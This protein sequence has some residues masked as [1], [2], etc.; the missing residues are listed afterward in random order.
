LKEKRINRNLHYLGIDPDRSKLL[1]IGL[2][3]SIITLT[4]VVVALFSAPTRVVAN[5]E[6][7][8][9]SNE[10]T[11]SIDSSVLPTPT[12]TPTPPI[13]SNLQDFEFD[14]NGKLTANYL[15]YPQDEDEECEAHSLTIGTYESF[16]E[17][18]ALDSDG[19]ALKVV[20]PNYQHGDCVAAW[21]DVG[22]DRSVVGHTMPHLHYDDS[23]DSVGD[24]DIDLEEEAVPQT[25]R[26][27]LHDDV[28]R[29]EVCF[30]NYYSRQNPV[31]VYWYQDG[32]DE[33]QLT[34]ELAYG[35]KNT[36]CFYSYLGH[37]F[38]TY[39]IKDHAGE[40][41]EYEI[42]DELVIQYIL[43][44]AFGE[45]PPYQNF[46]K[47]TDDFERSIEQTL[48][49]EW[50]RHTIP[51]RT[52][53]PLGFAKGRLPGDVFASMGSFYYNNRMNK[54]REEWDGKGYFVNWWET[55]VY[56]VQV[57]WNLKEKIQIRLRD[58]VSEWAGTNVEQ[59]VM[60]GLRQYESGARLLTHVDRLRTHVVSLIVNIAQGNLTEDWPV[61]VYDHDGRLHEVTM[62]PGD[63][64]FY[65][66]AKNLH[67]RN[68]AL[69]GANGYYVNLFT[70]YRPTEEGDT[71]YE[72]ESQH[73]PL[74]DV[75]G[76]CHS[77]DDKGYGKVKCDDPRLGKFV[78]PTLFRAESG[79][80]LIKWWRYTTPGGYVEK[81]KEPSDAEDE[82][83]DYQTHIDDDFPPDL[84]EDDDD[85]YADDGDFAEEGH[86]D[87][88]YNEK[89]EEVK[90]EL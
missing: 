58:L 47:K 64:V 69:S 30:L 28:F 2:M 17:L 63:I 80:D 48:R 77:D 56:F 71:W 14:I 4:T 10:A 32:K 55:D 7:I 18:V 24:I 8:T 12:P 50:T 49:S 81:N 75:E 51:K 5:D 83:R 54:I 45:T 31:K 19:D 20:F 33:E 74:L 43:V 21:L 35:D 67:S 42:I 34:M 25:F 66:S 16:Y 72:N 68:R 73:E 13:I 38:R 3:L 44:K 61:E 90:D 70:H 87:D 37:A 89:N 88:Y 15:V 76:E 29:K 6:T 65:E 79:E 26:E 40:G 84:E 82:A 46:G 53:S 59:T 41:A 23:D 39:G 85:E 9:P 86:D 1:S 22:T 57:P 36:K 27:W 78:S 52:F 11:A 62:E 60:Y